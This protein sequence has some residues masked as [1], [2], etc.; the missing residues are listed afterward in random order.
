LPTSFPY[1][2][3]PTLRDQQ[4]TFPEP[5]LT[6]TSTHSSKSTA[7]KAKYLNLFRLSSHPILLSPVSN[8]PSL[9]VIL[10]RQFKAC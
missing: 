4:S 7:G 5:H 3:L 10:N 9:F 6:T 2:P 1:S 8:F